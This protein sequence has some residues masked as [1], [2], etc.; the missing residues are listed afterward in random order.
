MN[1]E[2]EAKTERAVMI[3]PGLMV[4]LK[5]SCRG[6]VSYQRVDLD[7]ERAGVVAH[8]ELEGRTYCT[9]CQKDW[10]TG[11]AEEHAEG[12]V[13]G[14]RT[15]YRWETTKVVDDPKELEAAE[16]ARSKAVR[17]I[18]KHCA[19]TAFGLLCPEAN[20]QELRAGIRE[21]R[22]I[23]AAFNDGANHTHVAVHV[24]FGRVAADDVEATRAIAA[25]VR[26]L[27]E[28]MEGG[29]KAMNPKAIRN[30][31]DKAREVG[32]ML[33]EEQADKV[34]AAISQ[35]RKAARAIVA[36]VEKGGEDA[37]EVLQ[38]LQ[39]GAIQKARIAFLDLDGHE[40]ES[41]EPAMPAVNVQRMAALD[42]AATGTEG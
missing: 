38:E 41:A 30:A 23:V 12:C 42:I 25:E 16:F 5:T 18:D 31:A 7:A 6:G 8:P 27:L 19:R 39:R 40:G 22:A 32:A 15:V 4:A 33:G 11:Q 3:R 28:D 21:A 17:A 37:A 10:P 9:T 1:N 26:G 24:L 35:A 2:T 20:E 29:I 36:R 34:G 13:V 14:S